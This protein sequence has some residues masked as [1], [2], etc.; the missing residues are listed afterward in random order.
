M[1]RNR[2]RESTVLFAIFVLA[3]GFGARAN[4]VWAQ[5]GGVVLTPGGQVTTGLLEFRR[6]CAQCHG[7]SGKGNGPVAGSLKKKPADLTALSKNNGGKFPREHV[8]DVISGATVVE[9]HGTRE[10]PIWG[11]QMRRSPAAVLGAGGTQLRSPQRVKAEI[12]LITDYI[13]S[14]QVK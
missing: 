7:L 6:Y 3:L 1:S 14:Q 5:G 11:V 12:D 2:C 8:Y 4:P 13:E 9:A 10:M